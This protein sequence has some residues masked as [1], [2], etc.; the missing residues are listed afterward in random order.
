MSD[1][2]G[3][4]I[5]APSKFGKPGDDEPSTGGAILAKPKFTGSKNILL[6]FINVL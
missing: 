2:K 5:L 3:G 4:F 1:R 6:L